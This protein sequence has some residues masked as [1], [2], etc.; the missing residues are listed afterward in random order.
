ME[1]IGKWVLLDGMTHGSVVS[2]HVWRVTDVKKTRVYLEKTHK[3]GDKEAKFVQRKSVIAVFNDELSAQQAGQ[4]CW[5]LS[6]QWWSEAQRK[7]K[8]DQRDVIAGLGGKFI[9]TGV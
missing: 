7:C 8:D 9:K 1:L 4:Q 5:D 6:W 2:K 3:S